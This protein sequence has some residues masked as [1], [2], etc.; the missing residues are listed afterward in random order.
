MLRPHDLPEAVLRLVHGY[1]AQLK[2]SGDVIFCLLMVRY[3][4][5]VQ[6]E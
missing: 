5:H 6:R 1:G 4:I 2:G 3:Y